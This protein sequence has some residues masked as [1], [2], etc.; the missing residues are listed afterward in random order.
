MA[1]EMV[2]LKSKMATFK[3]FNSFVFIFF[4]VDVVVNTAYLLIEE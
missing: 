1:I 4:A 3:N 2:F